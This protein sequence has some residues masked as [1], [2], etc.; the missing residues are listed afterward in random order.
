MNL[1]FREIDPEDAEMILHWRTSP[2]AVTKFM[3]TVVDH[4]VE[5]QR[6]WILNYRKR[7][8]FYHWLI[9]DRED[10]G[11]ISLT[12][13]NPINKTASWGFISAMMNACDLAVGCLRPFTACFTHLGI[14]RM[15]EMLYFNSSVIDLH[16]LHGYS[17]AP[18]R[19][20]F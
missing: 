7:P 8:D 1:S 14:D 17:F 10:I 4:G 15:R 19:D 20:R 6:Q 2:R 11:Y 3:K 16:R 13:Y 5:E 18:Q 12:D 9:Q